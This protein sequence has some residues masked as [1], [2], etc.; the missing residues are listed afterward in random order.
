MRRWALAVLAMAAMLSRGEGAAAQALIGGGL[1]ALPPARL[2]PDLARN[3]G[4]ETLAGGLPAGWTAGAGWGVDH[5]VTHGGAAAYRRTAG[6]GT[7][8]QA[9][10]LKKG[11]YTFS[12]WIRTE[13]L[14]GSG[15]GVRLQLDMRPALGQWYTTDV[16]SGTR[17]WTRF[18]LTNLVVPQDL[19]ATLKLENYGGP[20]GTAWFDDVRLE[21]QLPEPVTVFM[22][23]PNF[24]GMMFD[25]QPATLRFDVAVVPPG[26]DA[27]AYLVRGTLADET[28]GLVVDSR[29]FAAAAGFTAALDGS[30][31]QYGRAY[32]ATFAL[33]DRAGGGVVG[34]YPAYRVS[35]VAAAARAT[36]NVSVD[37]GNR[38]LVRGQ[39][40]FVLGLYDSGG[41]Y[42]TADSYWENQIWSP[43]G[44]R[45]LDGLPINFYLN[46]W[47]GAASAEAMK[48]LMSNLQRRGVMYLQT[49]NCFDK[50]PAGPDLLV[51][52]SDAYVRAIGAH[53][54]SAGYYA[55]DE[56]RP[57]MVRGVFDQYVRLRALDP[58]SLTF[59]ALFGQAELELWRDAADVIATDPYP[60]FGAEPAGGYDHKRVAE[61]T[62]RSREVVKDS[63]PVMTV[64]QF[65]RATSLGR[66]PTLAEMRSHAT[67]AIVEGARGLWWWSVGNGRGAL[68]SAACSPPDAWCAQRVAYMSQLRTVVSELAALEPAL[69]AD[70]AP[71]AL[72]GNSDPAAIRTRVKRVNGRGYVFAYNATA[73][74]TTATLTWH[75]DPGTVVVHGEQRGL[76][77]GGRSFTDTF[78][79]Y[80]G[81]VYVLG[82]GDDVAAPPPA[83]PIT[84][85]PAPSPAPPPITTEPAPSPAPPPV[86]TEPAP[87]PP[88]PPVATEPAPSPAPPPVA[89]QPTPPPA[90]PVPAGR[91]SI[92]AAVLPSSRSVQVGRIATAYA[93]IVNTGPATAA[94]CGIAWSAGAPGTFVFQTTA[95]ATNAL[96]GTPNQV[97]D[98]PP[99]GAQTFFFA[100]T[101]SAAFA[102]HDVA[103]AFACANAAAAPVPGVNTLTLSASA[104][105]VADV[106]ALVATL[107]HDGIVDATP[108][109]GVF[110]VASVN[111]G[112]AAALT[113]VADTGG[114]PLP[115]SVT[116]C[117]TETATGACLAPPAPAA[118]F[119]L[120]GGATASF[121]VFVRALGPVPFD[122]AGHRVFVRFTDEA[123]IVRGTT[124]VAVR[125]R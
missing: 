118:P 94:G 124:S 115:V 64:L 48:A 11:V 7:A 103:P 78:G 75:A 34:Q 4:F 104:T 106:V 60:L 1:T 88:P 37:A 114:A 107:N 100:V 33:V 15:S 86:T 63:R 77:A 18:T 52:A 96:V 5:L 43:G 13:A 84:T 80:Q 81:H 62:I 6:A 85:E 67:M 42:S 122:P 97:V 105:P 82:G 19:T 90:P 125:T 101:P 36:M 51:H 89:T 46:Y 123:G 27:G 40:R 121:G 24:R 66:W 14:G 20:A 53:P 28:T 92:V 71:G 38:V 70:D 12:A 44:P 58:D 79:P 59:T 17:D 112:V 56:C 45:R 23:Y 3:G 91:T 113:A 68:A 72:A 47:M 93:T 116:L 95:S 35:R 109:G 32:A 99:G 98:I 25:D 21:Q 41:G 65:F 57:E 76:G 31:M 2:G 119:W 29:E 30:R 54:G 87:S 108:P 102:P 16:I 49:G 73:T 69:L 111:V 8:S 117:R 74:S 55:A 110:A 120:E 22:L 61:W 39:P 9:V 83:P 10:A 26:G 50:F